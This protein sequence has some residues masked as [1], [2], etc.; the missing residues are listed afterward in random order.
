MRRPLLIP[1]ADSPEAGQHSACHGSTGGDSHHRFETERVADFEHAGT[2][3]A[4]G[5]RLQ[6]PD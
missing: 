2:K 1:P 5:P 3:Q 6:A 4:D